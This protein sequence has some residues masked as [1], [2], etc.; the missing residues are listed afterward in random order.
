LRHF[1]RK[2]TPNPFKLLAK[3][4][5]EIDVFI[6]RKIFKH[7]IQENINRVCVCVRRPTLTMKLLSFDVG[8]KNLAFCL[9]EITDNKKFDIID[10]NVI[11]LLETEREPE[12]TPCCFIF[13]TP[14]KRNKKCLKPALYSYGT[15]HY[16]KSHVPKNLLMPIKNINKCRKEEL[17]EIINYHGEITRTEIIKRIQELMLTPIKKTISMNTSNDMCLIEIGRRISTL[18]PTIFDNHDLDYVIIENQISTIATRMKSIQCMLS[19]FF[20]MKYPF[21]HIEF[22]SSSNKL[23]IDEDIP[24]VKMKNGLLYLEKTNPNPNPKSSNPVLLINTET[25]LQNEIVSVGGV[26][27]GDAAATETPQKNK[28]REHKTDSIKHCKEYLANDDPESIKP[29]TILFNNSKKKD[30]LADSFLQGVWYI[31]HKL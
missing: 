6:S 22:V 5:K 12:K 26:G 9:F 14:K 23:K 24:F 18:L 7:I 3:T 16:C 31:K 20:I 25:D 4:L 1:I 29:T 11:S 10:W 17:K 15:N 2:T 30:D 27:G 21:C 19:Q 13:N 8:I 28:Y